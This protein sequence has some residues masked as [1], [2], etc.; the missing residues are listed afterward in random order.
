MLP[1]PPPPIAGRPMQPSPTHLTRA[2]LV[3]RY[4]NH[5]LDEPR[6]AEVRAAKREPGGGAEADLREERCERLPRE[7]GQERRRGGGGRSGGAGGEVE[8]VEVGAEVVAVVEAVDVVEVGVLEE[9]VAPAGG[10]G[11][12]EGGGGVG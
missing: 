2:H 8:L 3:E 5:R 6:Q 9:G 12:W 1:P 4:E 11:G 10:W 7:G